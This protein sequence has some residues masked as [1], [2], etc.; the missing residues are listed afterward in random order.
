VRGTSSGQHPRLLPRAHRLG[1][2]KPTNESWC[3]RA[4]LR[5]DRT[6]ATNTA[7]RTAEPAA[8]RRLAPPAGVRGCLER[9]GLINA[10]KRRWHM[11]CAGASS[12]SAHSRTAHTAARGQARARVTPAHARARHST[13]LLA[14]PLPRRTDNQQ[15]NTGRGRDTLDCARA[16]TRARRKRGYH[17]GR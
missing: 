13:H 11:M 6:A 1:P 2:A 8:P 5:A 14:G 3:G 7:V 4:R 10:N 17:H 16:S 12:P 9:L 15:T